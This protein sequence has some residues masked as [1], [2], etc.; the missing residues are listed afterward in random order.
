M[1]AAVLVLPTALRPPQPPPP[2]SSALSPD[3]PPDATEEVILTELGRGRSATAGGAFRV[4]STPNEP[5]VTTLPGLKPRKGTCFGDP[6]RQTES[7][8]AAACAQAFAGDNGGATYRNVTRNEVRVGIWHSTSM[9]NARGAVA[10]EPG[11]NEGAAARTHR[12]LQAYWNRNF[13]LYARRLQ[14][15]ALPDPGG[16]VAQARAAAVAADEEY[17]VF[18]STHLAPA[19]CDEL[20]RRTLVCYQ[21]DPVSQAAYT[22]RH[23]FWWGYQAATD[24]NEELVAEFVCKQLV[25][26]PAEFAGAAEAGRPRRVGVVYQSSADTGF[27][28]S[29]DFTAKLREECGV[30]PAA[31]ADLPNPTADGRA[32]AEIA[33][34]IA[35]FRSEG[36]TT[37]VNYTTLLTFL[38]MQQA[39]DASGYFPEWMLSGEYGLDF[40]DI[41]RL[42]PQG[43]MLHAFGLSGWEVPL[44]FA[45]TECYRAYKSM[46]P[47]AEPDESVCRIFFH[48]VMQ[49]V[50]GLQ[51]AG[52]ILTPETF[53]AGMYRYGY[54]RP[55]PPHAIFGGYGA[56]DHS[57]IDAFGAV[58]W[59]ATA[60]DPAGGEPGAFRWTR[61]GHRYLRGEIPADPLPLFREGIATTGTATKE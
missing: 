11:P 13:E 26:R 49:V 45:E 35:R 14:I 27:R 3:A 12:V 24:S 34:A 48:Q 53:A 22:E 28:T 44:P 4:A 59:D 32:G 33:S 56:G 61:G 2:T 5:Q 16:T 19:F 47:D 38:P 18:A 17:R 51:N 37:V 25:G 15:V 43:Q 39:A 55:P 20:A 58:W 50:N 31:T 8:Y 6:P 9:P 52:P 41:G 29:A 40:N 42:L 23:P 54:R 30:E 1:A 57:F 10:D 21:G 60:P 36:V 7:L 46:D